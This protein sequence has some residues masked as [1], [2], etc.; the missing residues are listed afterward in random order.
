[1][2]KGE[3]AA[4]SVTYPQELLSSGDDVPDYQSGAKRI[5]DMLV[6]GVENESALHLAC[7]GKVRTG[8]RTYPGS[9]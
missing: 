4:L 2:N 7:R 6:V 5:D 8:N 9:R 1:M 3:C